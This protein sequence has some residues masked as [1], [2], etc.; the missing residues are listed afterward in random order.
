MPYQLLIADAE[1][2]RQPRPLSG[3]RLSLG[4]AVD[5]DLSYPEDTGLS[6]HHLVLEKIGEQWWARDLG[7]KNGT[8]INE[9]PVRERVLLHDGDRIT[10]S[11]QCLVFEA[12]ADEPGQGTVIFEASH[13]PTEVSATHTVTLG[14]LIPGGEEQLSATG[15]LSARW[16]DPVTALVRAG[17]ELVTRKPM[18]QL[19]RDI[20]DLSLEAVGASRGVLLA[21]EGGELAVKACR[22]EQFRISAAVRDRVVNERTSLLVGDVTSDEVLRSRK[23]IVM[24][25]VHS[26]MA[27]PLQT[28]DRVLGLI[29]VDSPHAWRQFTA[30]DLN[31]LTVMANIAAMRIERERLAAAEQA[32]RILARDLEQAAEIQ[33]QFLP[34]GAPSPPGIELAGYNAPCR[35]VGGDYYDFIPRP[36]GKLLVVLGDVAGKGMPAALLMVNL[37]ARM[38]LLAEHPGEPAEM[39]SILNRGMATACPDNR[40]VTFFLGEIDPATGNLAFCN[41]GHDP[42]LLVR[43]GGQLESLEG[44]GPVLG[45]LP[46]LEY[47]PQASRLEPGDTVVV[48]TDGVTEAVNPAGEEF[49]RERLAELLVG[50]RARPV[51]EI[52]PAINEELRRFEAGAPATDDITILVARRTAA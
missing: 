7:S 12:A 35:S 37:Q 25:R 43:A 22:G 20:L 24:Q 46:R 42:P 1:G 26:L 16:R 48:Y 23:S 8:F 36:G 49:G 39:V 40:F 38:Q 31:L 47:Q 52:I 5:N 44:G 3:R 17:R 2:N 32:R 29:Y 15:E 45:I 21:G 9:Q 27:V 51:N 34:R 28:D 14:E 18:D 11:Q 19:F 50:L 6:R 41:A 4:R 13:S 10:V 30:D 33:R